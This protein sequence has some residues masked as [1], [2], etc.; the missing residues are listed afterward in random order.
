ME[1]NVSNQ[2]VGLDEFCFPRG[3]WEDSL[4]D[5]TADDLQNAMDF[6]LAGWAPYEALY[7]CAPPNFVLSKDSTVA[8]LLNNSPKTIFYRGADE[9]PLSI[10]LR[11]AKAT[12]VPDS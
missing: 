12:K 8:L 2:D 10:A 6:P 7:G 1:D 5:I 4:M 9:D 11:D 3:D